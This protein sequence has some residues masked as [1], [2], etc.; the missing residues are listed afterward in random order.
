MNKSIDRN[1]IV[2]ALLSLMREGVWTYGVLK[3]VAYALSRRG[4]SRV[5]I[6]DVC[7]DVQLATDE[8]TNEAEL[9]TMLEFTFDLLGQGH[10]LD[11]VRL[12]GDPETPE[13]LG[14]VSAE[15]QRAWWPRARPK[16]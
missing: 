8:S 14:R 3:E 4:L 5:E 2:V 13:E 6:M 11:I 16:E 9:D 15:A 10:P 12:H 1:A 7:Y